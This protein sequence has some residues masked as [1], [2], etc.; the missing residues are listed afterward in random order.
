MFKVSERELIDRA[1]SVKSKPSSFGPD[2]DLNAFT[3]EVGAQKK[4]SKLDDL[5]DEIKKRA[6]SAGMNIDEMHRAGSFFQMDH[7]SL[8][9]SSYQNG[10]EVMN[11]TDALK[12][13]DWLSE[14]RWNALNVDADKYTAAAELK[15]HQGYFLR[16]LPGVKCDVPV[17]ACLYMSRNHLAQHV[18]NIIIAEPGSELNIITGCTVGQHVNSGLHIGVSE[19]Y[20]KKD[21]QITFTMIHNWAED[22]SVRPRSTV[23]IE[24]NG[25]FMSNYICMKP[26]KTLQMYPTAYCVGENATARFY[27]ILLAHEGSTFDIGSRVCLQAQDSK[28][29][30]ITRAITEGGSIIARGHLVGE[31][32]NIKAH[33]ECRGLILSENGMIHAIPEL[34]AKTN[35]LDMSHEAAIGKIAA[36]EIQYLMARGLSS[37]EATSIIIRGF[38]DIKIR[39]LPECVEREIKNATRFK[40]QHDRLL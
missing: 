35:D 16:A 1:E 23:V 3:C 21:A 15:Q 17:Q 25:I 39:G 9:S 30:I 34:E 5:S 20:V 6:M 2:I 33:L 37:E 12:K 29:E 24:E 26:V 13:Y 7:S 28:A 31:V 10:I 14:Y 19:F 27:N 40:T 36:E 32:P 11:I 38:L 22:I 4:I 8:L 18:H